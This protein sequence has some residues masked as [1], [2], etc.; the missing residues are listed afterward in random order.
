MVERRRAEFRSIGFNAPAHLFHPP[1]GSVQASH[2]CPLF[3]LRA[4]RLLPRSSPRAL[5]RPLPPDSLK[6][7]PTPPP[8]LVHL[9]PPTDWDGTEEEWAQRA[10]RDKK[11]Y[12]VN[13]TVITSKAKISKKATVRNEVRRRIRD[14]VRV[15][16]MRGAVVQDGEL[17]CDKAREGPRKWL[18][19]GFSYMVHPTLDVYRAPFPQLVDEVGNA[20]R[21][22]KERIEAKQLEQEWATLT[23]SLPDSPPSEPTPPK[24]E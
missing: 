5:P 11:A 8:A 14:A 3:L 19:P 20:L 16:V 18:V 4:F 13:L 10:K 24:T 17:R 6:H 15:L 12:G 2:S 23:A 9:L 1:H 21:T 7:L 22:V